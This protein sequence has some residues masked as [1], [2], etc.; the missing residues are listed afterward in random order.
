MIIEW[1]VCSVPISE[2]T[3]FSN[4]QRAWKPFANIQGFMGRIGGW[5]IKNPLEAS[6]ITFWEDDQ[7]FQAFSDTQE[8]SGIN[9]YPSNEY[10]SLINTQVYQKKIDI[11][12]LTKQEVFSS[13]ADGGHLLKIG[14][15]RVKENSKEHFLLMQQSV[16]NL[17]MANTPGMNTGLVAESKGKSNRYLILTRWK[18]EEEYKAYEEHILPK[19][20]NWAYE[21]QVEEQFQG[22]LIELEQD[23]HTMARSIP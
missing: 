2:R 13:I 14:D 19:L 9:S 16:W 10:L 22:R 11:L 7:T 6:L 8:T 12:G 15:C 3:A 21:G 23:W 5:N 17:G 18:N 20:L 1:V 4:Y